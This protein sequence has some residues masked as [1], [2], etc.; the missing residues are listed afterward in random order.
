MGWMKVVEMSKP[1]GAETAIIGFPGV[2][3]VGEQ[4]ITYLV[5][6]KRAVPVMRIFSEY[7]IFPNNMVGISI[8]EDGKFSLPSVSVFQLKDPP[9]I[10]VTSDVQPVPWGSME[11]ANEIL[12]ALS[13]M[14]VRRIIVITGFVEES[15]AGKVIVFGNDGELLRAFL[16][17]DATKEDLIKVVVGLAGSVLGVAKIKGINSVVVSGVSPDYSPDPRAAKRVLQSLDSVFSLNLDFE[18][19]DRQIEEIDK[20]KSE[21]LREIERRIREEQG[22]QGEGSESTEYVG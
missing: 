18:S 8:T 15:A 17:A 20:I 9:L 14:G 11:I 1:V 7:L 22:L 10:L 21:I 13:N 4:V 6:E 5:R 16:E 19:L 12:K 3:N 2:A